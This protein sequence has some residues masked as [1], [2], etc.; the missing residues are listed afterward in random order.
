[1]TL[2]DL[3]HADRVVVPLEAGSLAD[4]VWALVERLGVVRSPAD[5]ERLRSRIEEERGED[6][7]ALGDRAFVMHYRTDA[8]REL[9]V[10]IGI[11]PTAIRREP[12]EGE[13]QEARIVLLLLAPPRLSARYLQ[14]LG[15]FVRLLSTPTAVQALQAAPSAAAVASLSAW[16]EIELPEQLS[17]REMMTEGPLTAGPATPL[18]EAARAMARARVAAV[19]VLDE[20][21]VLIGMLS[22]RE[23]MRHM[24]SRAYLGGARSRTA[25]RTDRRDTVVR[26]VMSRQVLCVSPDQPLAEVASLMSNKDVDRVPVVQNGRLVGMLTR[27][28]IVRKLIGF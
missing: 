17:V 3:V 25:G 26:D 8:V 14:A 18:R 7:V 22:E 2:A 13:S 5:G 10:A 19:P 20:A 28:D 16:R 4:A 27:S 15:G 1:V 23:L 6:I 11:A 21:G 12:G 9:A 24:L